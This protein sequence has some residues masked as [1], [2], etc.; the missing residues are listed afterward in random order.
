MKRLLSVFFVL[1]L[2]QASFGQLEGSL[3][4]T[5]GPDTTYQI[6]GDIWVN[7]SDTL[8]I[9][10]GN[11][12]TVG[13]TD[14]IITARKLAEPGHVADPNGNEVIYLELV[15]PGQTLDERQ[16]RG[17][18]DE[19]HINIDPG[20]SP[21]G[22]YL[23]GVTF[24]PDGNRVLLTNRM[25]DNVTVFDWQT[26]EVLANIPVGKWPGAV[27][28]NDEYAVVACAF[29]NVVY[30]I[31]LLD[32]GVVDT[33]ATG[34]Q[35]WVIRISPDGRYAYVAC[36]IGDVCEVI[37]L[38]T[39]QHERTIENFPI[40]LQMF[41]WISNSG[42]NSATFSGFEVSPD[43]NHLIVSDFEGRILFISTATGAL[44]D[45]IGGFG[46]CAL[47]LSGDGTT[48]VAIDELVTPA[49]AYRI[50]FLSHVI[51]DSV[52]I[53]GYSYFLPFNGTAAVNL[54]GS[55]CYIPVSDN[56]SAMVRFETGDFVIYDLNSTASA[57]WVGVTPDHRYAVSGQSRFSMVSFETETVV[58]SWWGLSQFCGAI[59]PVGGKVVAYDWGRYEGIYFFDISNPASPNYR[60]KTIS[61]Q[62]P[63]GDAPYR[64]AIAPNG[65]K[66]V[67][68]NTLSGNMSV[69]NLATLETEAI[70][71]AGDRSTEVEITSDSRWAVICATDG[72][73]VKIIDLAVNVIAA[74]LPT[75]AGTS[76][77]TISPD[78]AYAYV[79]NVRSDMVLVVMLNG[80]AS[81]VI[82]EIPSGEM[83]ISWAGFGVY[84]DVE[85][86]PSGAYV[87]VAASFDN[88]VRVIE[89]E[90]FSTV[91]ILNVGDFPL[92]IA[93]GG[94]DD[95]A[96]V[97]NFLGDSYSVLHID[98]AASEVVGT[99]PAGHLP[100]RLAY[101][102]TGDF[103]GI[104]LYAVG[105]VLKVDPHTGNVIGSDD[106]AAFGLV[107]QVAYDRFGE[108]VVL[109]TPTH[110]Q[111]PQLHRGAE[112]S[113]LPGLPASFALLASDVLAIVAVP[114]PDWAT[115]VQWDTMHPPSP[116]DLILPAIGDTVNSLNAQFVWT[117]SSDP[118]PNDMVSYEMWLDT[119]FDIS[120]A[121]EIA[122]GLSDTIFFFEG[123]ADDH[124]YYWTVHASD[125]NTTG[126][127]ANDT[128]MF[129]TYRPEPPASFALAEPQNGDTIYTTT[130]TLRWRT[131]FD[132]DPGDTIRY[133]LMWS[134]SSDFSI[135]EDTTV[136]DTFFTFP[137]ELLFSGG[138]AGGIAG[139]PLRVWRPTTAKKVG[140]LDE[141][142]D[143]STVYWKVEALD[144][145]GFCAS[146]EPEEGWSF[147][148]FIEQPPNSFDLSSPTNGDTLD[149]L[150]AE[151]IWEPS[152]D[153][154]PGDSV[155]FYR[156]YLA[157]DSTFST[158]LD[159]QDVSTT[160]L[161]W[162]ELIDSENYWWK[163]KAFDT[164]GNGTLSGE[165]WTFHIQSS[166]ISGEDVLLP[167]Q[168]ALHPNYPNPFNPTTEIQFD[169]PRSMTVE[170]RIYNILGQEVVT[171]VDRPMQ[172]GFHS[173]NFDGA[174]L[175]SGI[176]IYQLKA[177]DFVEAKKM[178][179]MR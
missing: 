78:D 89:T 150:T 114:G 175:S 145:F 29:D 77:V 16:V 75:G 50:D 131:S 112:H 66:A 121:S 57:F 130:P 99:F 148:V 82:A 161:V 143:D 70:L 28:T 15:E 136:C 81:A 149:S 33:F 25:T 51:I 174:K 63:E 46:Y 45:A 55:K 126:R 146:C 69:V 123:L 68:S 156:V 110:L 17:V 134:Y 31:S 172:A 9:L 54:D 1:V 14:K 39:L 85:V 96:I 154:D 124:T 129:R 41:S 177:G 92:Q 94:S 167:T 118:D 139:S 30:V 87:L 35:P 64:V 7:A 27:A 162:E 72:G 8:W 38:E 141:V 32:Y 135:L 13:L 95:Y 109:T 153:P 60:G 12:Q 111:L 163:V 58:G 169:L 79:G 56:S 40:C 65:S 100:L 88:Q 52:A 90:G 137:A 106:Y 62:E 117:A 165:A 138:F 155:A 159:S 93:F 147:H 71:P 133:R 10:D 140:R 128:L 37:D 53:N 67:V 73:T 3:R 36:D 151:L 160:A 120:H 86:S 171:L 176:Y 4:D 166:A 24:T 179:L 158:G 6:I 26:M 44:E 98:G 19:T 18:L 76:T 103:I 83:G 42:R 142:E 20:M 178:V 23:G 49:V 48:L 22:D 5:L 84:S 125:L 102:P 144:R 107:A 168:F 11:T 113:V 21:E 127:W 91:A 101:N 61:G 122:A 173:V 152:S 34:E 59:S 105:Q 47:A 170:L 132:P 43:G 97:T 80:A 104:C 2:A 119:L 108:A 116:F 74:D 164:H 157:L 115:V